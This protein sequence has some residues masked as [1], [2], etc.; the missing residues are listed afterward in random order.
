MNE[1]SLDTPFV[2]FT[3]EEVEAMDSDEMFARSAWTAGD[4]GGLMNGIAVEASQE[5]M[6][7]VEGGRFMASII[8]DEEDSFDPALQVGEAIIA[9]V[10][11]AMN[12]ARE[13]E[14]FHVSN[15]EFPDTDPAAV[16][17]QM[18]SLLENGNDAA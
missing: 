11:A 6:R 9:S 16:F 2:D 4:L 15:P 8:G 18:M 13:I 3:T 7:A 1:K 14:R 12:V 10:L 5:V 17:A